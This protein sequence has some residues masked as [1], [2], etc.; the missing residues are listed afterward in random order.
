MHV[1]SDHVLL[2]FDME[3]GAK[4]F[5]A[6]GQAYGNLDVIDGLSLCSVI[7]YTFTIDLIM[8]QRMEVLT[9]ANI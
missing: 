7:V 2:K 5:P 8:R 6:C 4:T 9:N 1:W 3:K